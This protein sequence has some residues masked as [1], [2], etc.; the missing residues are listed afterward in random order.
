VPKHT[1]PVPA[2]MHGH[3]TRDLRLD[4]QVHQVTGLVVAD[5]SKVRG[6]VLRSS[7]VHQGPLTVEAAYRAI[8][9]V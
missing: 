8:P 3:L 1:A 6:T 9:A 4:G 7:S 5:V 2:V